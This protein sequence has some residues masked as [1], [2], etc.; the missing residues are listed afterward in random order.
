MTGAKQAKTPFR[1][2]T[3]MKKSSPLI[4]TAV[5][6]VIL[7]FAAAA[8]VLPGSGCKPVPP[9]S[10]SLQIQL[11]ASGFTHPTALVEPRDGSGRLFITEQ[12]GAVRIVESSGRLL[13]APFLD[14]SDRMVKPLSAYDES[15]LLGIAFHPDYATNGFFYVYYTRDGVSDLTKRPIFYSFNGGPGTA[16]IWMHMGFTGPRAPLLFTKF[17]T[18]RLLHSSPLPVSLLKISLQP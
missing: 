10:P 17:Y 7:F 11:V 3:P 16:S 1:K 12:T 5:S 15:G 2:D 14:V 8:A 13:P 4:S 18:L 6:L 9:G